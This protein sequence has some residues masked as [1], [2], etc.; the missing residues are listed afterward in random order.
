M[1]TPLISCICVTR[2]DLAVPVICFWGQTYKNLEL[3]VVHEKESWPELDAMIAEDS[4]IKSVYVPLEPKQTLG[5]LY[6]IGVDRS[7]GEYFIV[8]DSDD[9][10]SP[11]RVR[12]QYD[13]AR[14][15]KKDA[16][17]LF[18]WTVYDHL[19]N[20]AFTSNKR[21]WE[22][23][24]LMAKKVFPRYRPG[25]H[26]DTPMIQAYGEQMIARMDRPELMI[27]GV[28]DKNATGRAHSERIMKLGQYLGPEESAGC[29]GIFEKIDREF[30][31]LI[32][33]AS[34]APST[35]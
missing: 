27:Y 3:V 14:E 13:Y 35:S 25:V 8:W 23:S 19:T 6:N 29:R 21:I 11:Y 18:R 26:C 15:K 33:G 20:Q 4:R 2:D 17:A 28:H 1:Q 12:Y 30:K 9:W 16:S 7:S 34:T 31:R 24:L 5:D 22:G 10:S 32:S